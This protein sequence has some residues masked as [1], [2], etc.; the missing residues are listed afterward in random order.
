MLTLLAVISSAR[1]PTCDVRSFGAVGDNYT[2]CTRAINDAIAACE[3]ILLPPGVFSS[4]TIALRN[5]TQ[6][7]LVAGAT[8]VGRVGELAPPAPNPFW[9]NESQF[10]D[11]AH[12]HW[13]DSLIIGDGVRNV[14]VRGPGTI[15][16]GVA[17]TTS[18]DCPPPGLGGK[19]I[20]LRSSSHVTLDG[21]ATARGGAFSL[22]AT[23]VEHLHVRGVRVRAESHI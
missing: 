11:F 3:H 9:T 13:H 16:G 10:E 15:D 2:S 8:L 6:I 14:T 17:L 7:T 18:A 5:D 23:D 22:L 20:A 4:G 21:F 19:L 1:R 12:A